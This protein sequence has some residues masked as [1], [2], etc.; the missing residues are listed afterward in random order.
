MTMGKTALVYT[1]RTT[2]GLLIPGSNSSP[3]L[4]VHFFYLFT[5]IKMSMK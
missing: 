5:L 4:S 2:A 1:N 3:C